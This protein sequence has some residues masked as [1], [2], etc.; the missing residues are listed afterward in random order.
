LQF[1][2]RAKDR[3]IIIEE[4]ITRNKAW[5]I[6]FNSKEHRFRMLKVE[7]QC[8]QTKKSIG[9]ERML[10]YKEISENFV[11]NDLSVYWGDPTNKDWQNLFFHIT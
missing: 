5:E 4:L 9:Y 1:I 10:N 3:D 11:K 7:Y 8:R 2:P 6:A